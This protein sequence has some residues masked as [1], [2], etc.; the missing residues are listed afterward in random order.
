MENCPKHNEQVPNNVCVACTRA[1]VCVRVMST[2]CYLF[3]L[4][5]FLTKKLKHREGKN[6]L[7]V[8]C[9]VKKKLP[10]NSMMCCDILWN[11]FRIF[12]LISQVSAVVILEY[13]APG[14]LTR[15]IPIK[16]TTCTRLK[17]RFTT[18]ERL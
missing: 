5:F 2:F 14:C 8:F 12:S 6:A 16:C 9:A 15:N 3:L 7:L 1:C 18:Y 11:G 10:I 13:T 4:F 17:Q